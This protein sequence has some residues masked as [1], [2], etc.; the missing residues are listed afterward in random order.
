[1]SKLIGFL[2]FILIGFMSY[3]IQ[4]LTFEEQTK[5]DWQCGKGKR[6]CQRVKSCVTKCAGCR[7]P[8]IIGNKYYCT[9]LN[10]CKAGEQC[11]RNSCQGIQYGQFYRYYPRDTDPCINHN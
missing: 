5:K 11:S 2:I 9:K 3:E 6:W 8:Y 10:Y 4:S 1:M 7:A